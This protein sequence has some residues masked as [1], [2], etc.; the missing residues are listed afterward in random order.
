VINIFP[1]IP[2][3]LLPP[4]RSSYITENKNQPISQMPKQLQDK[5]Y[6]EFRAISLSNSIIKL[7]FL[8]FEI[9]KDAAHKSKAKFATVLDGNNNIKSALFKEHVGNSIISM[10]PRHSKLFK[11][12]WFSPLAPSIVFYCLSF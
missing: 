12:N 6:F 7:Y 11:V 4:P 1:P 9:S 10:V 3:V 8:I 5:G 2:F